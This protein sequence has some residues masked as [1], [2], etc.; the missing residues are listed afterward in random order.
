[1]RH[2]PD[3]EL[4]LHF[5]GEG[6]DRRGARMHVEECQDCRRRFEELS[7]ALQAITTSDVPERGEDYGAEIW[8]RI[9]PKLEAPEPRPWRR[10]LFPIV[11]WPRLAM[12][13]G[14]AAIVAA[15]FAAGR[16]W[17]APVAPAAPVES[18]RAAV[19]PESAR[20]RILLVAVG[21]H[22]DRSRVLLTEIATS[23]GGGAADFPLEQATAA[24]LVATNRLYRQA[25]VQNGD[26]AVAA[27]LEDLERV[28]V[29]IASSPSSASHDDLARWREQIDS[30]GLLF[31]V[32][33]MGSR[34]RQR[35]QDA[36]AA[37]RAGA[38][39]ST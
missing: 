2:L 18:S 39:S 33:L 36:A 5:Y 8:A 15:A 11:T 34:V 14:A 26:P 38:K 10:R 28:L 1:M 19:P 31:K 37:S 9:Q 20:E 21:E 16:Y 6:N 25:A 7:K 22:L 35:Q 29:E 30:K 23:N 12:A 24:D 17:S 13:G 32:T 27:V 3:D 4:V